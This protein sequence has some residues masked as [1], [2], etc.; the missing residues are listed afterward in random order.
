MGRVG[1][2]LTF[3]FASFNCY[4]QFN[5]LYGYAW[6][7]G[8]SSGVD[9]I[10][11]SGAKPIN[12]R[13]YL[14]D[15]QVSANICDAFGNAKYAISRTFD[16]GGISS[17]G[18][19]YLVDTNGNVLKSDTF[20]RVGS[21]NDAG[22]FLPP[23]ND[24]IYTF[25]CTNYYTLTEIPNYKSFGLFYSRI[26]SSSDT[27]LSPG[28]T[29]ITTDTV[30]P[31]IKA[32]RHANGR[33]WWI[34]CRRATGNK[35][36]LYLQSPYGIEGPFMQSIGP[37]YNALEPNSEIDVSRDGSKIVFITVNGIVDVF[38]FDRCTGTLS[39]Y[40]DL[41]QLPL[42]IIN[43]YSGCSF[44]PNGKRLYVSQAS[45]LWQFDLDS[46]DPASSK[47]LIWYNT[48]WE[49]SNYVNIGL[50]QQERGPDNRIYITA[51]NFGYSYDTVMNETTSLS[52]INKPDELGD[53]CDFQ[54]YSFLL[55]GKKPR[56]A[57]PNMPDYKLGALKGS[58]CDSIRGVAP[59]ELS[60]TWLYPSPGSQSFYLTN[61]HGQNV[62]VSVYDLLGRRVFFEPLTNVV[63]VVNM[64]QK[65][66]GLYIVQLTQA[67][68]I[69]ENGKWL[70][71]Q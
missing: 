56:R 42:D 11:P 39:N 19:P 70:K 67:D 23:F 40:L 6:L 52:V 2:L 5:N 26:D 15:R 45:S 57:L 43:L 22:F 62:F 4:C 18:R 71:A 3:F 59:I 37:T 44:S 34:I 14:K 51:S 31:A 60:R 41:R 48:H 38:D 46:P 21:S 10:G 32:I 16:N 63:Q 33:D 7:F 53:S 50:G 13:C 12:S 25:W 1:F 54:P 47:T 55:N 29:Y 24:A 61:T 64:H 66:A 49:Q 9:F 65:P 36:V 35:F 30:Y 58:E 69:V 17:S 28:Y 20:I 27:L 68:Q 8:D